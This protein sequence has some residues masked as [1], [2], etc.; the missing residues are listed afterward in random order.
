MGFPKGAKSPLILFI[1]RVKTP[2]V[3]KDKDYMTK[4]LVDIYIK[5]KI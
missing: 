1:S 2:I 3:G 4:V 5:R